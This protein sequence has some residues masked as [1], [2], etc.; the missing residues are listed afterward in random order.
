MNAVLYASG[1]S[2]GHLA[3]AIALA[4]EE[5]R[6][7]GIRGEVWVATTKKVVDQRLQQGYPELSFRSFD[8]HPLMGGP[9]ETVKALIKNLVGT[10]DAARFLTEHYVSRVMATGGFGCVPVLVAATA[11]G[12]PTLLHESNSVPGK[13][14]RWFRPLLMRFY[15]TRLFLAKSRVKQGQTRSVGFP[16][17]KDF[18]PI[19]KGKARLKFCLEADKPLVTVIG[20]SQGARA[21]TLAAETCCKQWIQ[22]GY[23]VVCVTG[24]KNYQ[25]QVCDQKRMK[26]ISFVDDMAALLSATDVLVARSG[27]GSIAEIAKIGCPSILVPLPGSADDHQRMNA[28]VF[29]S[30]GCAEILD[31]DRLEL[32]EEKVDILMKDSLFRSRMIDSLKEWSSRNDVSTVVNELRGASLELVV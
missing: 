13:V 4:Q 20:G 18:V 19:E 29:A 30:T 25:P 12:V 1:G 21:L 7:V 23:Q 11:L 26:V 14:S 22:K 24:P 6:Q 27:A 15:V 32:L 10:L 9:G 17:R 3:P 28:H 2:G 8:S 31:Q 16:L 5:L